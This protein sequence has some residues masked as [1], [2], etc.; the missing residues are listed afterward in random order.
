[1]VFEGSPNRANQT[2]GEWPGLKK[3]SRAA[4]PQRPNIIQKNTNS[5]VFV[6][7]SS[8]VRFTPE[9][10]ITGKSSPAG[11]GAVS[12][13]VLSAGRLF[14]SVADGLTAP[15]PDGQQLLFG[16]YKK[17]WPFSD[18]TSLR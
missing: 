10:K 2:N 12:N 5:G 1:V 7:D 17:D 3:K 6:G 18:L 8:F 16:F 4:R 13:F 15:S 14:T 9:N 11:R